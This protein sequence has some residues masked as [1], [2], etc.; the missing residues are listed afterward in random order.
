M[1]IPLVCCNSDDID[2]VKKILTYKVREITGRRPHLECCQLH[3]NGRHFRSR[4]RLHGTDYV[5]GDARSSAFR[6]DRSGL[7]GY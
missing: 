6:S 7:Q 5:A 4:N 2:A 3:Q 1:T